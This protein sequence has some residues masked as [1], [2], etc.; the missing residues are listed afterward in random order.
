MPFFILLI[1]I[2]FLGKS[3]RLFAAIIGAMLFPIIGWFTLSLALPFIIFL[4]PLGF[5]LGLISPIFFFRGGYFGGMGGG[6]FSSGGFGGFGGGSFGGGGAS[7]G[8]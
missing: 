4:I 6:G 8:W 2:S 7:G 5:V 1:V 3:K